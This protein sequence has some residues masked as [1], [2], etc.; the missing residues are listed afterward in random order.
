M[1]HFDAGILYGWS[2]LQFVPHTDYKVVEI[3]TVKNY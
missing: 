3:I 2:Q 1:I